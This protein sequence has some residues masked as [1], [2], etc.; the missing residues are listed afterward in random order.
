MAVDVRRICPVRQSFGVE[1]DPQLLEGARRAHSIA[2][3]TGA[4]W[5]CV[6]MRLRGAGKRQH[7]Q[8]NQREQAPHCHDAEYATPAPSAQ[9]QLPCAPPPASS[10]VARH[11]EP[12]LPYG[13]A[14]LAL[15]LPQWTF[16]SGP[17][18][19]ERG[20]DDTVALW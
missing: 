12:R 11:S 1:L 14:R 5:L 13:A 6:L 20:S 10:H 15:D 4:P 8:P 18:A 2:G 9:G 7:Q 19:L 16:R 3:I 17:S